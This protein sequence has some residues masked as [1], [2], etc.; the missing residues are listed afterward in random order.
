MSDPRREAPSEAD[1][2]RAMEAFG[3]GTDRRDNPA[4]KLDPALAKF[5]KTA[6]AVADYQRVRAD[7]QALRPDESPRFTDAEGRTAYFA[8]RQNMVPRMAERAAAE[9]DEATARELA[10]YVAELRALLPA[11]TARVEAERAEEEADRA[12]ESQAYAYP[13]PPPR[14]CRS[15]GGR[16]VWLYHGTTTKRLRA[17]LREGIRPDVPRRRRLETDPGRAFLT[18]NAGGSMRSGQAPGAGMYA[19]RAAEQWGGDPVVLRVIVPWAVLSPDS[20]D[21]DLSCAD[22]QWE[23]TE[24]ILPEQIM[25]VGSKRRR[26]A[27]ETDEPWRLGHSGP[28][29]RRRAN[30]PDRRAARDAADLSD[31]LAGSSHKEVVFHGSNVRGLTSLRPDAGREF[32]IFVSP[33]RAYAARHGD[34]IYRAYVSAKRPLVV[35]DKSEV[36]PRDLTREDAARLARMGYDSIV[37]GK[38]EIVLFDE[39][40]VLL[41]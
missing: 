21:A 29:D 15:W 8:L 19:Q 9:G 22:Y 35:A 18:A 17:I 4:P 13:Y 41:V 5:P 25:E 6:R 31:F 12:W 38:Q 40:Q 32:G 10:D 24:T 16:L 23:T 26:P 27:I 30:P 14:S 1:L 33:R 39:R 7:Y 20:D 34:V 2:R 28:R 11:E 36:S 3:A 37:S